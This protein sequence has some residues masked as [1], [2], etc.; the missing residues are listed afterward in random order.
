MF[1]FGLILWVNDLFLS[2]QILLFLSSDLVLSV[3]NA[4]LG[5]DF[6]TI[7]IIRL[8]LK[9]VQFIKLAIK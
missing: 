3:Q 9:S 1:S 4:F 5:S 8:D 7:K 6:G 2:T